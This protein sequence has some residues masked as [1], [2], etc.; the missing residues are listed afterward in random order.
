MSVNIWRF[1]NKNHG[2]CDVLKDKKQLKSYKK[3]LRDI[4]ARNKV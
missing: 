4:K 2:T 1:S 3:V